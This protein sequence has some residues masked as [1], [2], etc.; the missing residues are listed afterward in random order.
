MKIITGGSIPAYS[1]NDEEILCETLQNY[2]SK[3]ADNSKENLCDMFILPFNNNIITAPQQVLAYNT[4]NVADSDVFIAAGFPMCTVPHH[5]K[6]IYLQETFPDLY[7][8]FDCNNTA[9]EK[10]QREIIKKNLI[11][12]ERQAYTAPNVKIFAGSEILQNDLQER[13]NVTAEILPAPFLPP[14][15]ILFSDSD[16]KILDKLQK[17]EFF[18]TEST[19]N[20]ETRINELADKLEKLNKP[21]A[22]FVPN[23]NE[24]YV[25]EIKDKINKIILIK[26]HI[27]EEIFEKTTGYLHFD[28]NVRKIKG[29]VIRAVKCNVP[30][31]YTDGCGGAAELLSK[32]KNAVLTD[33]D[34]IAECANKLK[35]KNT[36][37]KY[38]N[39]KD[40]KEFAERLKG[41]NE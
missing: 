11:Y 16:R 19:L 35:I 31:I 2:Y 27:T 20:P 14:K 6:R 17:N 39:T 38:D 10:E 15:R 8:Q 34:M 29:A 24:K 18:V 30:V 25:N 40:I 5:N 28:R 7:E 22:L 36:Y 26:G 21:L 32:Y 4:L 41:L 3:D 33:T 13:F 23:A 12:A 9:A 37:R 1:Y